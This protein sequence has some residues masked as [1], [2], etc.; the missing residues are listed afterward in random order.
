MEKVKLD[1]NII[2][3]KNF[4]N[5]DEIKILM[6]LAVN[7]SEKEWSKF[8]KSAGYPGE[9]IDFWE[10]KN[11]IMYQFKDWYLN[12]KHKIIDIHKKMSDIINENIKSS[13]NF[14]D[15]Q[16]I[17]RFRSGESMQEHYDKQYNDKIFYASIIYL[18][19]DFNGGELYYPNLGFSITPE[20][21]MMLAHPSTEKYLHG[22]NPVSNGTR[23]ML[24]SI[25]L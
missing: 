16:F 6:D 4:L 20:P 24:T 19:N 10:N 25:G 22:V 7:A 11:L 23:Y 12:N 9:D 15:F 2:L 5:K 8:S 17:Q 18:N 1:D 3:Y 13:Y 14:N 21:G